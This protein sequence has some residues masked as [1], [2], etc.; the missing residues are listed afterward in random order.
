VNQHKRNVDGMHKAVR[1]KRDKIAEHVA[2]VIDNLFLRNEEISFSVIAKVTNVSKAWLYRH[3]DLRKK[4]EDL[5]LQQATSI[6]ELTKDSQAAFVKTLKN[7]IKK[8]E[9]ENNE[10]RKQLEV[11]YGELY[12]KSK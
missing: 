4:I 2:K 5:H 1:A 11:V 8:L 10:L 6:K 7:R 12:L 9:T 3:T